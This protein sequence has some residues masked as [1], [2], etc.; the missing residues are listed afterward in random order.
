MLGYLATT[1]I[2]YPGLLG[3][4][5]SGL[6]SSLALGPQAAL[7]LSWRVSYSVDKQMAAA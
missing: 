1:H 2:L 3:V 4:T 6:Y 7:Q 5:A